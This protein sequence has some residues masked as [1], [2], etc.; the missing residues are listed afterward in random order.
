MITVITKLTFPPEMEDQIESITSRS[1]EIFN[2]LPGFI[3]I[4]ISKSFDKNGTCSYLKWDSIEDHENC[5]KN[6]AWSELNPEW[7][8][9]MGRD[10]VDFQ[11][12]FI[13]EPKW[14]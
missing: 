5:M 1:V 10:E 8:A 14:T 6:D 13:G 12:I 2:K 7:D 11:F 4:E 3:S 9:I